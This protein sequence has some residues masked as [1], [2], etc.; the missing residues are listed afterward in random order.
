MLS[1]L[2]NS[3]VGFFLFAKLAGRLPETWL[4]VEGP[5]KPE[6]SLLLQR[7]IAWALPE[8]RTPPLCDEQSA[9]VEVLGSQC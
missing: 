2:F 1:A 4:F 7:V 3:F 8:D 9:L 6:G 5:E